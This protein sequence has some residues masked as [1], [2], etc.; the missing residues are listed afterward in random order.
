MAI[1]HM[2]AKILSRSSRNTIGAAAYRS[3]CK[4]V[5]KQI[6]KSFDFR[7]KSVQHV[8]LL[9]PE[10]APSWAKDLQKL[11]TDD[12]QNGVQQFVEQVEAAEKR[13]DAQVYR[14]LEFA[15]PQEFTEEQNF[16]LAREFL[17]DQCCKLGIT[18]LANFHLD[19]DGETGEYKPHCHALLLTRRLEENGLSL[20]KERA[21]NTKS[22]L[23][24]WREQWATYANFHLKLNGFENAIDYRSNR[25]RGIELEAQPKQGKGVKEME[26]RLQQQQRDLKDKHLE[27]VED[28]KDSLKVKKLPAQIYLFPFESENFVKA[29]SSD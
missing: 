7:S 2:S 16:A 1:Y 15:L 10:G 23:L 20:H 29:A 11:I 13:K 19:R 4:L 22:Q 24:E 25:D 28:T 5:D 9:L 21:W 18:V 14:E 27:G 26:R 6:E 3:G 8:E 12:R 17:E